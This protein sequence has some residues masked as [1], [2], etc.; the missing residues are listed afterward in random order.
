MKIR[1]DF[2]KLLA[3]T[4]L[5]GAALLAQAQPAV[6]LL[7]ASYDPTQ[8]MY[9]DYRQAFIQHWKAKTGHEV[10]IRQSHGGSGKQARSIIDGLEADV[11]TLA[12]AG[13][14]DALHTHG[15]WVPKDWQKR[16]PFI[17]APYRAGSL[18]PSCIKKQ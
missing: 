16:L 17:S 5:T 3:T 14:S 1:C 12:L 4:A 15:G 11:A 13:D 6:S 7:N 2:I 8:K 10:S 9:V 18:Y